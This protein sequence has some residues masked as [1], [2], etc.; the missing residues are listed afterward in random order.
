M[1]SNNPYA[2]A[3]WPNPTNPHSIND[4]PWRPNTHPPTYGALPPL[5][6]KPASVLVFTF[7][8]FNPDLFN[9]VVTGP[10]NSKY[11]EVHTNSGTTVIS[12]P[13]QQIAAIQWTRHPTVE[14]SGIIARQLTKDFL[15]LSNDQTYDLH[16]AKYFVGHWLI[17]L[18][19]QVDGCWRPHILLGSQGKP[20]NICK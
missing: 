12:K 3:G 1:F 7:T 19:I 14:A 8:S 15:K 6:N 20:W 9:C 4:G 17:V 2:Q 11:F 18:Q 16:F 5:D 13:G 10:N